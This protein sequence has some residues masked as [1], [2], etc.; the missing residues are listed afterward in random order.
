M[1]YEEAVLKYFNSGKRPHQR[2]KFRASV[3]A[4]WK[5][6]QCTEAGLHKF[7][8]KNV[9]KL[10]AKE[11]PK[12]AQKL[13]KIAKAAYK[14]FHTELLE[15]WCCL[16]ST[17]SVFLSSAFRDC[18]GF[19]TRFAPQLATDTHGMLTRILLTFGQK[20]RFCSSTF[21]S[22]LTCICLCSRL[23]NALRE[24]EV[25]RAKKALHHF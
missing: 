19:V 3:L 18:K 2:F 22:E 13:L 10:L 8:S 25:F 7:C 5:I 6:L 4:T 12:V 15:S 9:K 1:C 14:M 20:Q 21:A 17:S 23:L 16:N 24:T 11:S